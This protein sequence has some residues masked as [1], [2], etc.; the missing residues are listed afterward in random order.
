MQR[1]AVDDGH[2]RA[3]AVRGGAA[4]ALGRAGGAGGQHYGAAV[5][6]G[7]LELFAGDRGGDQL[8]V[9]PLV[10][11]VHLGGEAEDALGELAVVDQDAQ[12]L[13]LGHGAQ[14]SRGQAGV[15]QDGVRAEQHRGD[16]RLDQAVVVA[17]EHADPVAGLDAEVGPEGAGQ[18]L[19]A[20]QQFLVRHG[21][22][23]LVDHRDAAGVAG[24]GLAQLPGEAPAPPAQR[25]EL[26]DDPDRAARGE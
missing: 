7:R 24:G 22:A 3:E 20:L 9:P 8:L 25:V 16:Y 4:G 19:G 18:P 1:D 5:P 2:Q 26:R 14:L 23:A 6:L 17:A 13:F 11:P 15:D 10:D 12:A 21:G